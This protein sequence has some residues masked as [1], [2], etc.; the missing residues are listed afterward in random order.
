MPAGSVGGVSSFW[1]EDEAKA[2]QIAVASHANALQAL[3]EHTVSGREAERAR[4]RELHDQL[5]KASERRVAR[6]QATCDEAVRRMTT[7]V[8]AAAPNIFSQT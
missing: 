3:T 8:A 5:S 2:A 7:E 6:A 1:A 4:Q